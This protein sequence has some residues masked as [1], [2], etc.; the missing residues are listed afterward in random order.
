MAKIPYSQTSKP[1]VDWEEKMEKEWGHA[2]VHESGHALMATLH[3]I[4]CY[5]VYY[6][7]TEN[8]GKFCTLIP[9]KPPSE[10][11]AKDYLFSAAGSAAEKLIY[12]IHDEEAARA[13]KTDFGSLDS[14]SFDEALKDASKILSVKRRHLK[15]LI[16]MLKAK[17]RQVD[18]NLGRLPEMGMGGTDKRYLMLLSKDELES[19]VNHS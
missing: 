5:G 2:F 17:V 13:D 16:S 1:T 4:P 15:R 7:R 19:A 9:P 12:G 14:P 3:E 11:T 8:S 6:Q 10:R 18:Y